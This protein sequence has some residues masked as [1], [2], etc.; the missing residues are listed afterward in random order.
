MPSRLPGAIG[1]PAHRHE[2]ALGDRLPV[3]VAVAAP[4]SSTQ[5][6]VSI[7]AGSSLSTSSWL[8]RR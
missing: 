5:S 1:G 7:R 6:S 4:S 8:R 2:V 3:G